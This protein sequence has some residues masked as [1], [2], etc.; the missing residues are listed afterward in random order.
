[1]R[2]VFGLYLDIQKQIDIED[3]SN[4]EVKG[5]WKS[6]VGKWNRGDLSEGWY[7][8]ATKQRADKAVATGAVAPQQGKNPHV[9]PEEDAPIQPKHLLEDGDED[10]DYGPS[11][12]TP[13]VISGR[14]GPAIPSMQ[15]ISYRNELAS[16]DKEALRNDIR[17]ARKIDRKAQKER[18]D[19]LV[20]RAEPGTRERQLEKKKEF[21]AANR[22]FREAKSP[23]AEEI[24]EGELMGEDGAEGLKAHIKQLER[25]K[26]ERELRK[27]EALRA[28]M[29]E[30]EERLAEHR[31]KEDKT[32]DML[33][34][35]AKQRY[36]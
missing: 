25:K 27:E 12:P 1:M 30:R 33:K 11:L 2:P 29:A 26:T 22:S 5:R 19:E 20:P 36:G 17:F 23:G 31:A 15:D 14:I 32:M 35:L 13:R 28:R 21:A 8:P 7:D 6:Y 10:D 34:A 3:L 18:L 24:K 4:D 16:E 9:R